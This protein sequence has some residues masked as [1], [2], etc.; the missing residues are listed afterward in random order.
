MEAL[1]LAPAVLEEDVEAQLVTYC[2][3][4]DALEVHVVNIE[5]SVAQ[6]GA[7]QPKQYFA[8]QR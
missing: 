5:E 7:L 6:V 8:G 2:V 3:N 1:Y 4:A